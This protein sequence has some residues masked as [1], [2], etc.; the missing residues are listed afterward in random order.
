MNRLGKLPFNLVGLTVLSAGLSACTGMTESPETGADAAADV[1]AWDAAAGGRDADANRGAPATPDTGVSDAN[2]GLGEAAKPSDAT[3]V[4][5]AAPGTGDATSTAQDG[6]D[7]ATALPALDAG[8]DATDA[9]DSAPTDLGDAGPSST[10]ATAFLGNPAHTSS[11]LDPTLAPP[12]AAIW[13]FEPALGLSISYPLVAGGR[14]YFVYGS[15]TG[16]T[17][18][19]GAVDEHTGAMIWGPVDLEALYVAGQAYDGEQVFTVDDGG[20]VRAFD[21]ATGAP[22]WTYALGGTLSGEQPPTAYKGLL[23]VVD[24]ALLTALDE[25]T[26][27]VTW[28]APISGSSVSSPAVTDDGV[29]VAAGCGDV[30]A[31]D[32]ATGSLLWHHLGTCIGLAA[33][34]AVFDGRVYV[35]ESAVS[36]STEET[37]VFDAGTGEFLGSLP[38]VIS[39]AF[40]EGQAYCDLR[41][42]LAAFDLT[43][44][45]QAWIFLGDQQLNLGPF[46]AAGVVYVA[47]NTG[48]MFAVDQATGALVWSTEIDP[49]GASSFT[50]GAEGVLLTQLYGGGGVVAYAHLDSPDAGVVLGDGGPPTPFTLIPG[51]SPTALAIDDTNLYWADF[52][53]AQVFEA[54][55]SGGSP[56]MLWSS[57]TTQP[58]AIAVDQTN[59]YVVASG[60]YQGTPSEI[61]AVPIEGTS[62]PLPLA[63]SPDLLAGPVVAGPSL[64]YWVDEDVESVLKTGGTATSAVPGVAAVALAVDASNLYWSA[65]DGIYRQPF[66]GGSDQLL[67]VPA[68][69]EPTT[70]TGYAATAIA[71]DGTNVYYTLNNVA[72]SVGYIPIGGGPATVLASGRPASLDAVA[73]DDRNVYW[74]EGDGTIQQGAIAA[75]PKAGG[76]V[77]VLVSGLSDPTSVVV[78]STGVYYQ[79]AG[80]GIGKIAK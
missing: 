18:Q 19:L 15:N 59:V 5:D 27:Q 6:G 42:A 13:S 14:A 56:V 62:A 30:S 61:T 67:G 68:D 53:A 17:Q 11:V 22:S 23:Y 4:V 28:T 76:Q 20:L 39:P 77:A 36:G 41:S 52:G 58:R 71:L 1:G 38:C 47:S 50:V 7:D 75:V 55:K 37:D 78:D 66:S 40:D 45:A 2:A 24:G 63:S 46:A 21:A 79:S 70:P 43:T 80:G 69:P 64:L 65:A 72:G 60:D 51:A 57:T 49:L 16:S 73:V 34:P 74:V 54:P 31:F 8:E 10:T 29:F 33:T 12:L 48:M 25:G 3:S 26:G 44:G 32:P 9:T 35:P